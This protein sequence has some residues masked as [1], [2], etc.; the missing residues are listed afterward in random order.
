MKYKNNL[1]NQLE[2]LSS[3]LGYTECSTCDLNTTS[4]RVPTWFKDVENSQYKILV[5]GSNPGIS[6]KNRPFQ[7]KIGSIIKQL[8]TKVG[9]WDYCSFTNIVKCCPVVVEGGWKVKTGSITQPIISSCSPQILS[10]LKKVEWDLVLSLGNDATRFLLGDRMKGINS[11][12]GSFYD[13]EY[14][15]KV[16]PLISPASILRTGSQVDLKKIIYALYKVKAYL[17]GHSIEDKSKSVV[18]SITYIRNTDQ[19]SKI[20]CKF[21]KLKPEVAYDIEY[22]PESFSSDKQKILCAAIA[23]SK[24]EVYFFPLYHR[25]A[26]EWRDEGVSADDIFTGMYEILRKC[27]VIYAH[28]VSADATTTFHALKREVGIDWWDY[29]VFRDTVV[30]HY[31]VDRD[32]FHRLDEIAKSLGYSDYKEGPSTWLANC[33]L[34]AE[35][36]KSTGYGLVPLSILA[37]Y[38]CLDS[39]VT[40]DFASQ[41]I[42]QIDKNPLWRSAWYDQLSVMSNIY[43]EIENDGCYIDV[44]YAKSLVSEYSDKMRDLK[45]KFISHPDVFSRLVELGLPVGEFYS[46]IDLID[47]GDRLGFTNLNS[48]QQKNLLLYGDVITQKKDRTTGEVL[49]EWSFRPAGLR[50]PPP[51]KVPGAHGF[52]TDK[53][54]RLKFIAEFKELAIK[55]G[56]G[57]VDEYGELHIDHG[58]LCT[59]YGK[60][61]FDDTIDKTRRY[62]VMHLLHEYSRLDKQ[63]SG[64]LKPACTKWVSAD[65]GLYHTSFKVHGT[66]TGRLASGIHTIPKRPDTMRMIKSRFKDGFILLRDYSAIEVR[67]LASFSGDK[68]LIDI[69][70]NDLLDMHRQVASFAF[71]IPY[72]DITVAQRRICKTVHFGL[73]YLESNESLAGRIK[74]K[75]ETFD[76]CLNRVIEFKKGYYKEFP[77]IPEYIDRMQSDLKKYGVCHPFEDMLDISIKCKPRDTNRYICTPVGR[78][79]P[80]PYNSSDWH[81]QVWP[82]NWPIQSTAT[83]ITSSAVCKIVREFKKLCLNSVVFVNTH[84]SI[85]IDCHPEEI[86]T[87]LDITQRIMESPSDKFRL[88]VPAKSDVELG[89]TNGDTEE[90]QDRG[91]K[92]GRTVESSLSISV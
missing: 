83:D 17:T 29:S 30:M 42:S 67:V 37:P 9:L 79:L 43:P 92:K 68:K 34:P 69:F 45:L 77:C 86:D 48:T 6:E 59:S 53:E 72:E 5:V 58:R 81:M 4:V 85:G 75:N 54:V 16:M 2:V 47:L 78:M 19:I 51:S 74:Q 84:D 88:K 65:T 18:D 11:V 7:G 60:T 70:N 27:S 24:E 1:P 66:V 26:S 63:V 71:K 25:E 76:E 61:I 87:V 35:D 33:K 56:V 49:R 82:V 10:D 73:I 8:F 3:K 41:T 23:L 22:L 64:Y 55:L 80:V 32:S 15:V 40:I 21:D 12:H 89:P 13:S 14:G 52:S 38:N 20:V 57:Y 36:I 91:M 62:Y 46:P 44:D 31:L 90:L 39:V 28:N 50:L